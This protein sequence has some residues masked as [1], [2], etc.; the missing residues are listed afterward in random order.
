MLASEDDLLCAEVICERSM[1]IAGD[2]CIYTNHN[3]TKE[4]LTIDVPA[5]IKIPQNPNSVLEPLL[6]YLNLEFTHLSADSNNVEFAD[7]T[8]S[9]T[10]LKVALRYLARKH[11]T[12]LLGRTPNEM[13]AVE[14]SSLLHESMISD[15]LDC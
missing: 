4:V 1:R 15:K 8:F 9:T 2:L 10:D 6:T 7:E 11:R 13:A 14:I 3:L 12:A 5:Q